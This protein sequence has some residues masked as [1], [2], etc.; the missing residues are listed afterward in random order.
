MRRKKNK[1]ISVICIFAL[2]ITICTS[3]VPALANNDNF[4]L[5][6]DKG[7]QAVSMSDVTLIAKSVENASGYQY[8]FTEQYNGNTIIL[9][10]YSEANTYVWKPYKSGKYILGVDIKDADGNDKAS[11]TYQFNALPFGIDVSTHQKEIDW[12]K[13]SQSGVEFAM[14]RAGYGRYTA[15]KDQQDKYFIQNYNNAKANGLKVGVYH[16]SYATTVEG[17]KA[18]AE[19]CLN[20]LNGRQLDLPVAF[21]IEDP[22]HSGLSQQLITDMIVAFC[23]TIKAGGYQPMVYSYASFINNNIDYSRT[24]NYPI[25]V[26]HINTDKPSCEYPYLMWQYSHTGYVPGVKGNVDLNVWYNVS[27]ENP[28]IPQT[29]NDPETPA[30]PDPENPQETLIGECTGNNVNVRTGPST[31]YSRITMV[32]KGTQFDILGSQN[33][34]Y[35]IR[36]QNGTIGWMIGD[37]VKIIDSSSQ[38]NAL[39]QCTGDYVNVRTGPS[40]SYSRITMVNKGTQFDILGSQNGWYNIRLQNG[41]IGWMIGDYVKVFDGS[42]N[43]QDETIAQCTGDYVNI[44]TGPGTSYKRITMIN[45]GVKFTVL[46]S[47]NGWYNVKL[48]NGTVGWIIGDYVKSVNISSTTEGQCT[49]NKVNIRSGPGTG[50]RQIT[51]IN[52]GDKFIILGSKSG[53]Y[54]IQLPDGT[55]GWIIG[56]YVRVI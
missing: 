1:I 40:T 10:D 52:K 27:D 26:A 31:S 35:N 22:R 55:I 33:G 44:R 3:A 48:Q 25:W 28:N 5:T 24:S 18:E 29:P 38:Y 36:L 13:V 14:I 12:E 50:N 19:F 4:S 23:E 49:G 42:D 46:G 53:W 9:K 45:R 32:N 37:Y 6:T 34:W 2:L 39:G 41:T 51:R 54:N 47:Q 20:I 17:A 56:D 43:G 8:R 16:Y 11:L 30:I 21:D 15:G 7:W